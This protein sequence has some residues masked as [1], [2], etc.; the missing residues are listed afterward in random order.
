MFP[1]DISYSTRKLFQIEV[2]ELS[3]KED[4]E[5]G[6]KRVKGEEEESK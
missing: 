6:E 5:E 2:K 1:G 3:I 4:R